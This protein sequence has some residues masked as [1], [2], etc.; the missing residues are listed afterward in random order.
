MPI[1]YRIIEIKAVGSGSSGDTAG[2]LLLY[3]TLQDS[4]LFQV[5][6]EVHLTLEDHGIC[7]KH[8]PSTVKWRS[9]HRCS[10]NDYDQALG[11]ALLC[12]NNLEV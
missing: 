6:T 8:I 1:L 7:A 11:K 3:R 4:H 9:S 5:V 12:L 2:H 10:C